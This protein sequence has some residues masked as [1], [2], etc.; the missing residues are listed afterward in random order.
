MARKQDATDIVTVARMKTELRISATDIEHDSLI[1]A[2]LRGAAS[3]CSAHLGQPVVEATDSFH[4]APPASA[5][6]PLVVPVWDG[7]DLVNIA[8]W[9]TSGALRLEADGE[10]LPADL[11]RT[12]ELLRRTAIWPPANGWP[13]V[14]PRSTFAVTVRRGLDLEAHRWRGIE[15]AIILMTR[16]LYNATPYTKTDA[17]VFALLRPYRR[18]I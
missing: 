6:D 1:A 7:A 2:Q 16:R 10:L 4:V 3:W 8:Y 9:S 17:A 15:Q 12:S 18:I 14:L 5:D 13:A 11:G